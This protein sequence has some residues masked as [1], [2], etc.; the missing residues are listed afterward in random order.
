MS[1]TFTFGAPGPGQQGLQ[2]EME[3]AIP[4]IGEFP[5]GPS[6]IPNLA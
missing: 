6:P 5:G 4:K 2:P 3:Y 1:H